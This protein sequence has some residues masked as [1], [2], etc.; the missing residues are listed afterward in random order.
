[1]IETV[2]FFGMKMK[3]PNVNFDKLILEGALLCLKNFQGPLDVVIDLGAHA[4]GFAVYAAKKGA[5]RVYAYEADTENFKC[6]EE[7]IAMNQLKDII[8]PY[9]RFVA[10]QSDKLY[11]LYDG[12]QSGMHSLYWA[13]NHIRERVKTIAFKEILGEFD[14]IDYLKI[15]VEGAE[16][17]FIEPTE[18]I[19][20]LFQRVRYLDIQYH[21]QMITHFSS[22]GDKVDKELLEK[23]KWNFDTCEEYMREFLKTCG[24]YD[25]YGGWNKKIFGV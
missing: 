15:D 18:E 17:E 25:F 14:K 22:L 6:L 3:V 10:A 8:I 21:P 19:R 13:S 9:H 12:N 20:T 11:P 5:K 4:G 2:D 23:I 7:N 16:F 1:M 24:F